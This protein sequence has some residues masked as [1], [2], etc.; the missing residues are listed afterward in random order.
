VNGS[1]VTQPRGGVCA[2]PIDSHCHLQYFEPGEVDQ[3]LDQARAAGVTGFLVPAVRLDDC[4]R[5]L[6]LAQREPDVWCALG[7]H[8]HE[9]KTWQDG[10]Q[11]RLAELLEEPGVVAVGECGLDFHYDL[12]PRGVQERVMK[13]Q[14]EL[15]HEKNLP[16]IV[17]NR[18]SNVEMLAAVEDPA[19]DGL[20]GVLH[21]Y[22]GGPELAV[23]A[24]ARGFY[25]GMSGMVTF[26]G[27]DNVR[28]VLTEAPRDRLLVETDTP[29]LAPVPYRGQKN[30]PAWVVE[31]AKRVAEELDMTFADLCATTGENFRDLFSRS[32]VRSPR[33][34][35]APGDVRP[36]DV[37]PL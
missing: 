27:A 13:K 6:E 35:T 2:G 36:G 22:A 28:E 29:Y 25:L 16:V 19:F 1:G 4:E 34:S 26:R 21:S 7:V 37:R 18:D 30:R 12:S 17:H 33:R 32:D 11:R 15:A 31:V 24:I 9:A 14:W 5:L 20:R 10:D 3:V 8:P 23:R